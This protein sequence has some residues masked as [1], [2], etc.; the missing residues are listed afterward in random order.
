MVASSTGALRG[1]VLAPF[2]FTLY[3]S[4]FR[5]NS[6]S[7]HLQRFSDDT[8]IIGRVSEGN[9]LEYKGVIADFVNWRRVSHL[10]I[11]ASKTKELVIDFNRSVP[12]T[13]PV[14]SR[15]WTLRF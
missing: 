1:I 13:T 6:D 8:S 5:H 9:D 3:T 7:C 10:H 14:T 12:Q 4:D 11:D 2:L 15:V